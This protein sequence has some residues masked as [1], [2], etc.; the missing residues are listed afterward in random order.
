MLLV[1]YYFRGPLDL[2]QLV[3][4]A[5]YEAQTS[6]P[7]AA[8]CCHTGFRQLWNSTFCSQHAGARHKTSSSS[9]SLEASRLDSVETIFQI[10][11]ASTSACCGLVETLVARGIPI[12]VTVLITIVKTST[13]AGASSVP[14][15]QLA[16]LSTILR[17]VQV[18]LLA[19]PVPC[20]VNKVT[21]AEG[22]NGSLLI[23]RSRV[24]NSH[25]QY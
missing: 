4:P 7:Q 5:N 1:P 10:T 9:S 13:L 12:I 16:M 11:K 15:S 8:G 14:Q 20:K 19:D 23:S 21:S 6:K 25:K 2:Y 3:H 18:A 22:D 17:A 24:Y